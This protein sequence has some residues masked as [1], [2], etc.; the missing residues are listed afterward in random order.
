MIQTFKDLHKI[1]IQDQQMNLEVQDSELPKDTNLNTEIN[2]QF[3]DKVNENILPEA[4]T[5]TANNQNINDNNKD[6]DIQ[7]SKDID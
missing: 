2:T 5:I 6:K 7:N 1:A 4:D 3:D